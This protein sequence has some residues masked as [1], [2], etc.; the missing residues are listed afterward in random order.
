MYLH[1]RL[2]LGI[3]AVTLAALCISILVPLA[4][5]RGDVS[6]E[7]ES[8]MQLARL[9][10]DVEGRVVRAPVSAEALRSAADEVRRSEPLRH[11][12]VALVD[13]AGGVIAVSPTDEPQGSG[14]ARSLLPPDSGAT[15][16][17]PVVY[18][19]APLAQLRVL[20][21]PL[22][23]I[24]EIEQRVF[25]DL[26]LL[27]LTILAMAASIYIMVRR[28]L[29]PVALIQAAL[30][31]LEAGDLDTRLPRFRLRD[32]DDISQRFNHCAA[33]MH[34]AEVQRRELT[35]RL[36]AVEEEER[37]RLAREL[38]DEL[39]QSLTAIKVDAA[40][41]VRETAGSAPKIEACARGIDRLAGEII[42]MI[43]GMLAR[44]RPHGLETVGLRDTLQELVNSWQTRVADKFRC[45]LQF[46]GPVNSLPSDL[47][48]T[49]YRLIQECL[50][51]AVRHSRAR[52]IT[53]S[54]AVDAERVSLAVLESDIASEGVSTAVS[55]TGL[56]GMRERVQ[57]HGGELR[58]DSD[59]SGGMSLHAWMPVRLPEAAVAGG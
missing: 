36:I 55:G 50:T 15:L 9:L 30:T 42:G 48:I 57:A 33:A 20:S 2:L 17:Y 13:L 6:R 54:L 7:T 35:H 10:H 32:L 28:G 34:S 47:N 24:A 16:S 39:G 23:E 40:Y 52:T 31:R 46:S 51:N 4:S 8:S 3:A 14:L 22:S 58:V 5:V 29:K 43:R 25:R 1:T 26:A 18:R 49:V 56:L 12:K 21:N 41:I 19:G 27:A 44:L 38:H 59:A 11:V 37:R 53:I 45:A